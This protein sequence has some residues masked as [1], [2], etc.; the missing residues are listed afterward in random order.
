VKRYLLFI[1]IILLGGCKKIT[2]SPDIPPTITSYQPSEI[3]L[4]KH[5]GDVIEFLITASDSDNDEISYKFIKDDKIVHFD[6]SYTW[7]VD[8]KGIITILGIAYNDLADTTKWT[9]SVENR[10]PQAKS[11][12]LNMVEDEGKILPRDIFGTDPDGDHLTFTPINKQHATWGFS[13]NNIGLLLELDYYG[14]ASIEFEASDGEL[15]DTGMV[16]IEITP[17]NDYPWIDEFPDTS[18]NEDEIPI[19]MIVQDISC[20]ITDVDD[21]LNTLTL[22]L[23]QS[24]PELIRLGFNTDSSSIIVE[25]LQSEGNGSSDITLRATDPQGLGGESTFT[26]TVNPMV[27]ISGTIL[28]TDTQEPN[29]ALQAWVVVNGDTAWADN[30]GNYS[31]QP[32]EPTSA[33]EIQAG[34]KQ[35][36]AP[37]SYVTTIR[38]IDATNDVT[39]FDIAIVTYL[40]MNTT[41]EEFR[42]MIDDVNAKDGKMRAPMHGMVWYLTKKT[43]KYGREFSEQEWNRLQETVNEVNSYLKNSLPIILDYSG[44]YP[45]T[46]AEKTGKITI[47][48]RNDAGVGSIAVLDYDDNNI[49]DHVRI[50]LL[51][52]YNYPGAVYEEGASA[53]VGFDDTVSTSLVGGKTIF[54][55]FEA[56]D[57]IT[58]ADIKAIK[59]AENLTYEIGNLWPKI[60]IDDIL[61]IQE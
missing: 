55:E 9:V 50:S 23:V 1:I 21:E 44:W 61:K 39:Y 14:I 48:K 2:T 7:E 42:I 37:I 16:T 31:A 12:S 45:G 22:E 17:V 10:A 47:V 3:M 19:G 18:G 25:Y 27:D 51:N 58:T 59:L 33:L 57:I 56:I 28:D 5:I 8:G 41:S 13:N 26:F 46:E 36:G 29:T 20:K 34:Y 53:L 24:N 38:D 4:S 6:S 15:A 30:Q 35:N 32:D 60:P 11:F 49:I 43:D 40:N 54:Y 52:P